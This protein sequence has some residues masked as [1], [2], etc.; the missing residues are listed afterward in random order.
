ML[1]DLRSIP[2]GRVK[3]VR[4]GGGVEDVHETV[5]LNFRLDVRT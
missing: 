1:A 2:C 3:Q 4:V 5:L